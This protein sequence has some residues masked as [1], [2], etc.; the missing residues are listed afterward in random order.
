MSTVHD[1]WVEGATY[2]KFM[3]RWSRV[4]AS[5]FVT[6]LRIP[7]GAHW[8]DV[9]C[10]TGAMSQAIC[11]LAN[12][13]STLGC[14]LARPF[15]EYARAHCTD[16]RASFQTAGIGSLPRR[17]G[18]YGSI[19]SLLALN[20]FPDPSAA[21]QEM[22]TL[23]A[24]GAT[25]SACVW[26]YSEGMEFLRYFWDAVAEVDPGSTS[27]HEGTRFPLCQGGA[28]KEV[29][30][31]NGLHGVRC[32]PMEIPTGFLDFDDYWTPFL[33]GTGPAPT[34]VASLDA[35]RL[36]T[37]VRRLQKSLPARQDGSIPLRARAWAVRGNIA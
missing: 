26:D 36:S 2:E 13:A 22:S 35:T 12:P 20:F 9:G 14:D 1:R 18:G 8:L 11:A 10:G 15:V 17:T 3:G 34:Y 19:T 27:L 7:E 28:L 4:L 23:T 30:E 24:R 29:F 25:L 33:G 31:R 32:E 37:L 16:S 5:A 6:W 21:I